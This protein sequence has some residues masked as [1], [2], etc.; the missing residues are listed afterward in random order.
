MYPPVG[1][2]SA[3]CLRGLRLQRRAPRRVARRWA[4]LLQS[5]RRR[6]QAPGIDFQI[7]VPLPRRDHLP[8]LGLARLSPTTRWTG[9]RCAADLGDDS[10]HR[11]SA[12]GRGTPGSLSTSAGAACGGCV[13]QRKTTLIMLPSTTSIRFVPAGYL[14]SDDRLPA[15]LVPRLAARLAPRPGPYWSRS[16]PGIRDAIRAGLDL[17]YRWP[18]GWQGVSRVRRQLTHSGPARCRSRRTRR[19]WRS[20]WST[21]SSMPSSEPCMTWCPCTR[22]RPM[23]FTHRGGRPAAAA[24]AAAWCLRLPRCH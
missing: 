1:A 20:P 17:P 7:D 5:P 15:H 12:R 19:P 18:A 4:I 11:R 9:V 13:P 2:W 6:P 24:R 21:N 10:G 8:T 22:R 14:L 16:T 23:S 3:L